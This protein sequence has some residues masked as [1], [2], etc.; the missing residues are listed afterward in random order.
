MVGYQIIVQ[1][2]LDESWSEWFDDVIVSHK[3]NGTTLLTGNLPDQG[4][5]F[6]IFHKIRDMNLTLISVKRIDAFEFGGEACQ[7]GC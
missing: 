2:Y 1:G 4:R 6:A 7:N 5:L 3:P